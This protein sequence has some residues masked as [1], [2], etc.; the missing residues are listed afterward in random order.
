TFPTSPNPYGEAARAL[1]VARDTEG[2]PL[3]VGSAGDPR[4]RQK[5]HA[6]E[7][8]WWCEV[9]RVDVEWFESR[10]QAHAAE[11]FWIARICPVHNR[12]MPPWR[13]PGMPGRPADWAAAF[14]GPAARAWDALAEGAE[15]EEVAASLG[16]HPRYLVRFGRKRRHPWAVGYCGRWDDV[17]PDR[18][19]DYV[20][21]R[22]R[23]G[24]ASG[25]WR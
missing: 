4:L 25:H 7:K 9:G 6:T 12:Q 5:Q 1:Y 19:Y 13:V 8:P 14:G 22:T 2:E 3:Y 10:W 18:G 17:P 24:G 21:L 15:L 16:W 11:Q 20:N 23:R